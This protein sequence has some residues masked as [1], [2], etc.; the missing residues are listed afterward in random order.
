[1][2]ILRAMKTAISIPDHLFE[3]AD[4]LAAARGVSRSEL[5]AEAVARYVEAQKGLGVRERLDAIY[6]RDS[7]ISALQPEVAA[8]Q[9]RSL[10]GKKW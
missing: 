5:Y 8:L 7:E 3:E 9:T 6:S 2:V 4:R 1:V 10:R